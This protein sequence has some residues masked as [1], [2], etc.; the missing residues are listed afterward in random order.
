MVLA[1]LPSDE[2]EVALLR[3]SRDAGK[4]F[5]ERPPGR[6]PRSQAPRMSRSARRTPPATRVTVSRYYN[7]PGETSARPRSNSHATP[8]AGSGTGW[9]KTRHVFPHARPEPARGL[10]HG[11]VLHAGGVRALLADACS[12]PLAQDPARL[13]RRDGLPHSPFRDEDCVSA[14]LFLFRRN[15]HASR[16]ISRPRSRRSGPTPANTAIRL[17]CTTHRHLP[18]PVSRCCGRRSRISFGSI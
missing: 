14:D 11:A 6:P 7:G 15:S 5:R 10:A 12:A 16:S 17:A 3:P 4:P 8:W 13:I 2:A 9:R 18:R 1:A